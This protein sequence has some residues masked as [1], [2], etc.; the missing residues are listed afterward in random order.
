MS[1]A[2][3][4]TL[5]LSRLGPQHPQRQ[6]L[7]QQLSWTTAGKRGEERVKRKFNEFYMEE[8][9]RILWDVNLK[10]GTWSVQ[11]DGLLLTEKGA[12]IIESK[13]ISGQLHF[14]EKTGEFSR[15]NLAGERSVMENPKI[16]LRKHIRFLT[17]YFKMKKINLPISG[18]IV[19]TA[20]DCEFIS[21]PHGVSVCKTY[22]MIEYL[23]R[24]LQA[25]PLEAENCKLAKIQKLIVT[26]QTPYEHPPLCSYYFIDPKEL[27]SGVFC[28]SCQSLSMQ[29][30]NKSWLCKNCGFQ[31]PSAHLLAIQEYFSFVETTITN[32]KLRAFCGFE[33]R[34]VATRLL[35]QLD[36][37][38]VGQS[39]SRSYQLRK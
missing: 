34:S 14:D 6:F 3:A 22:Q 9:F 13:N 7:E 19:F 23:L 15:V 17:H 28:S 25:F 12:I 38:R 10:I 36:L 37:K 4:L 21:K 35:C 27:Q 39:K 1:Q 2:E 30:L 11:M 32:Q 8:D 18:L 16:Q 33:S 5:L 29:R 31:N 24:I 26:N 20:K